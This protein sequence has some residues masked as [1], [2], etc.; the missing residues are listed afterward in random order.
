MS[1]PRDQLQGLTLQGGWVV[2]ERIPKFQSDTGSNFS[3]GYVVESATGEKRF[4]KAID[5]TEA[6]GASDP[7]RALQILV[8][9]FNLERDVLTVS[10]RMSC[11]V[12]AIEDGSALVGN[13]PNTQ[14][15]QYLIFELA[16][17]SLRRM[18]VGPNPLP[19]S[20]ALVALRRVATGLRQLHLNHVA[21]QDSK[22]SNILKFG[23]IEFKVADVGRASIRGRAAPHDHLNYA[24]D[25]LYS[26]PELIYGQIDPDFNVRRLGCDA[27]MLG[28]LAAFLATQSSI[29]A[30]IMK[31]LDVT[32]QPASWR[33]TY[34][35]VLSQVRQAFE[36]VLIHIDQI[37]PPSAPY[38]A[39][40]LQCI[41]ELCDP[42]PL[43]RGHPMTRAVQGGHGNV[44]D[45]ERYITIFDILALKAKRF[46][47]QN[48]G[49]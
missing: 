36:R 24:G 41:A 38:R 34:P 27:Y 30:L 19:M 35:Q 39:E 47:R 43:V 26:P 42:D 1:R 12:T 46:E 3:T 22:P 15:V 31:E 18:A 7:A 25:P 21:H 44:Y 5:F 48:S 40:L 23:G 33:G 32:A 6:L 13:G 45:L 17:T 28:G 37:L 10:K 9:A 14:T 4:L 29:T 16:E 11:V 20:T 49:P 8:E 2:R